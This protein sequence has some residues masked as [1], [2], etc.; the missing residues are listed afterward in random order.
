VVDAP[1]VNTDWIP[2]LLEIAGLPV[3]AGL[4]AVSFARLLRGYGSDSPRPFFWHFPHYNNQGGRPGGAMRDG[5]WKLVEY[6][7]AAD[8]P[9]LYNLK[10]DIGERTNVAARN[11]D[12]VRSMRGAL[13]RWR[14]AIG[15]QVNTPNPGFVADRYREIYLDTDISRF[16]PAQAKEAEWT[17]VQNWRKAMNAAVQPAGKNGR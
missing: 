3:P 10:A 9:E 15:A 11:A 17:A 1:V 5:E 7:D 8:E 14:T 6:Y 12:R 16:A 4:D 2:T 13:A